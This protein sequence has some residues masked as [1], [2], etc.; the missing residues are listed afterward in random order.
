MSKITRK[1]VIYI[2]GL[3]RLSL[4]EDEIEKF[5]EQMEKI[6]GYMDKL[7]E[8]DTAGAEPYYHPVSLK[9][10][11]REDKVIPCDCAEEILAGAPESEAGF[12]KVNKI[13]E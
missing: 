3:A 13:I 8:A 1:D 2:A 5:T 10:A 6:L 12:F 9:N 7:N 11:W 4:T